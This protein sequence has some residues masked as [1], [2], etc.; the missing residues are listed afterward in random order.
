VRLEGPYTRT[1][2]R[3]I[4]TKGS[5]RCQWCF[6]WTEIYPGY[7]WAGLKILS[8][9]KDKKRK[10]KP[11]LPIGDYRSWEAYAAANAGHFMCQRETCVADRRQAM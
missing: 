8:S 1:E 6:H 10:A 11:N 3:L 5:L 4:R 9:Q 2:K 7:D